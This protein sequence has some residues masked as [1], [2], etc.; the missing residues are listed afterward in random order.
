MNPRIYRIVVG[1]FIWLAVLTLINY[2][3]ESGYSWIYVALGALLNS[4]ALEFVVPALV[5]LGQRL[6]WVSND[7]SK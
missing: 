4:L 5:R 2:S 7:D 1:F 3:S 6:G